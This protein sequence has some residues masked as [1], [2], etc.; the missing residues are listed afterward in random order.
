MEILQD[1]MV[2]F[3]ALKV[4]L[5]LE[6]TF[7]NVDDELSH[8][9]FKTKNRPIL[10]SDDITDWLK[11]EHAKIMKEADESKEKKSGW[12]LASV[13]QLI[14]H[15]HKYSPMRGS[16][17]IPLPEWIMKKGACINVHN[18]DNMCFKYTMLSKFVEDQKHASRV[19][20]YDN[21]QH[22]YDF[23]CIRFPPSL[24]E[25]NKFGSRNNVSINIFGLEKEKFYP[26]LVCKEELDDHRDLL[27]LDDGEKRH[28]IWIK[29]F[30]R[31][32]R[33]QISKH[34]GSIEIC[35]RCFTHFNG[36]DAAIKLE[37]HKA[38]CNNNH[39]I[40]AE[41]PKEDY[42]EFKEYEKMQKVPIIIYCDFEAML[43]PIQ[44]CNPDPQRS[45]TTAYQ[46]HELSS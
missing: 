30:E 17:Y 9:A 1:N 29:D 8:R 32:L 42:I 27:L 36:D 38:Y 40:R 13:N 6:A 37:E 19:S 14:I 46:Y 7:T 35:K 39:C 31:L 2:D 28:F 10:E 41:F 16:S 4:N 25:V 43:S 26:L 5:K 23:S 44:T 45:S 21:L 15:V 20:K 18:D 12:T 11:E 24:E 3:K 33:S 22:T 34:H